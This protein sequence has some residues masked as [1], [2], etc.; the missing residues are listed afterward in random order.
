V[1]LVVGRFNTMRAAIITLSLVCVVFAAHADDLDLIVDFK[2]SADSRGQAYGRLTSAYFPA[3]AAKLATLIGN[4]RVLTGIGPRTKQPWSEPQLSEGDRIGCTLGQ[5]WS[6]H[7]NAANTRGQNIDLMLALLE[8]TSVGQGRQLAISEIKALLRFGRQ[9]SDPSLSPL[10]TIL[11]RL[12]RF[13]RD[14]KPP[15]YFRQEIVGILFEHGDPNEYLDLAIELSSTEDTPRRQADVL[16][17]CTP[18]SQATK[19]TKA[20]RKKYVRHCFELLERVDDGRTGAGCVLA[21]HVGEFLGIP[22]VRT[23]EGS[24]APDPKLKRYRDRNGNITVNFY[25]DTVVNARKWWNEHK[26]KY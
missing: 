9:S 4:H 25:H 12:D 1:I 23:T 8:D 6:Y 26:S 19:F 15:N 14:P 21:M 7:V 5:L 18:T 2:V 13:A 20:N 17:L 10:D 24:F 22:P 11:I 3:I 16:C